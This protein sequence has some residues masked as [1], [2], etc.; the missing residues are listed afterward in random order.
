MSVV[1]TVT[2]LNQQH[3]IHIVYGYCRH[4]CPLSDHLMII[5]DIMMLCAGFL[6]IDWIK[7]PMNKL[8]KQYLTTDHEND[9]Y[10]ISNGIVNRKQYDGFWDDPV[11]I[12]SS[13]QPAIVSL[14]NKLQKRPTHYQVSLM[15]YIDFSK[16]SPYRKYILVNGFA[17]INCKKCSVD[18]IKIIHLVYVNIVLNNYCK[19]VSRGFEH[20]SFPLIG[21]VEMGS[22]I[23]SKIYIL[24]KLTASKYRKTK[25]YLIEKNIL[26]IEN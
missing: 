5:D 2:L 17:R 7:Y 14:H 11:F 19:S 6:S 4:I 3:S 20:L 21:N 26:Q 8:M 23:H 9:Q 22:F 13:I 12:A 25:Q 16:D 1:H 15:G 18:I 10:L 24:A